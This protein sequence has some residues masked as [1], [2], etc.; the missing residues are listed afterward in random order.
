MFG[1]KVNYKYIFVLFR[2]NSTVH[3][4]HAIIQKLRCTRSGPHGHGPSLTAPKPE[5]LSAALR[6]PLDLLIFRISTN[7]VLC[8]T[9]L[10]SRR[11][12]LKKKTKQKKAEDQ[13]P[14]R[15]E[16]RPR[17]RVPVPR[18]SALASWPGLFNYSH[19]HPVQ[20]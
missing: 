18:Q 20:Q 14:N 11:S 17:D 19:L 9:G 7:S 15:G 5:F 10:R 1:K 12:F 8:C 6:E 3:G 16:V 13:I 2:G 4:F